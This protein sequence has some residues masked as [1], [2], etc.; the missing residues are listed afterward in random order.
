ME[1]EF[2]V[3]GEAFSFGRA[4][5][6][7]MV[8]ELKALRV[9]GCCDLRY[10]CSRGCTHKAAASVYLG[11]VARCGAASEGQQEARSTFGVGDS[12]VRATGGRSTSRFR[13]RH[14]IDSA[15]DRAN[16][17]CVSGHD[18]TCR[19]VRMRAFSVVE[20]TIGRGPDRYLQPSRRGGHQRGSRPPSM[21]R[22]DRIDPDRVASGAVE[23]DR[24]EQLPRAGERRAV[25]VPKIV[26]PQRSEAHSVPRLEPPAQR[27]A[28]SGRPKTLQNTRSSE[29]V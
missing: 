9:R 24:D 15:R 2:D 21:P 27:R 10:G 4:N 19:G 20:R 7:E 1:G 13:D 29:E 18:A 25:C 11:E 26:K 17:R 6:V 14:L 3:F 22:D 23:R 28:V 5:R 12:H 16:D 8:G